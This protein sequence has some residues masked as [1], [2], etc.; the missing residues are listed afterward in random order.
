M[1]AI[2]VVIFHAYQYSREGTGQP[3]GVYV[4]TPWHALFH[5]LDSAVAWFFVLSGF[6][7]FL[8]FARA[9]IERDERPS[10]RGF[11][12]RRAVRILPPYYLARSCGP[13]DT[14]G[15]QW[16]TLA[17]HLTPAAV[18]KRRGLVAPVLARVAPPIAPCAASPGA[19]GEVAALRLTR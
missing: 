3:D 6:L 2:L 13:G 8:P 4:G 18:E 9:A 7:V 12:V 15:T 11:L 10:V 5:N 19:P 16:R 17:E 14:A 1:A